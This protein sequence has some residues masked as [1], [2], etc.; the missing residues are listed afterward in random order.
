MWICW[1]RS[2]SW[3]SSCTG[4]RA[5]FITSWNSKTAISI[6]SNRN[7]GASTSESTHRWTGG[8]SWN[9]SL[10]GL[11]HDHIIL[12]LATER[13]TLSCLC[14]RRWYQPLYSNPFHLIVPHMLLLCYQIQYA[15][16]YFQIE[17]TSIG[18]CYRA[19]FS[20][21]KKC[22]PLPAKLVLSTL[23]SWCCSL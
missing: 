4:M 10:R 17:W 23:F 7:L 5:Y 9:L 11:I 3:T 6:S 1:K 13:F 18:V 14:T 21:R 22:H 8:L 15:D 2:S 20:S 16:A 12:S 19:R